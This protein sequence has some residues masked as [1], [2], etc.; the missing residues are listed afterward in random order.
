MTDV[1]TKSQRAFC[2]SR[3]RGTNTKPEL[4]LRRELWRRGLR[5]RLKVTLAGKPDITFKSA[6]VLVFVDGCFWHG[7]PVHAVKPLTNADFWR[8]KIDR[9]RARDHKITQALESGGWVVL[10][11]W[12]HEIKQ[13]L[14]QSADKIEDTI[15]GRLDRFAPNQRSQELR[16][17]H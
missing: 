11:I 8:E 3:I 14:L 1:L 9:N 7:C 2:M 4:A 15:R 12:E 17:H 6:R 5:Y 13:H 10:R 16:S